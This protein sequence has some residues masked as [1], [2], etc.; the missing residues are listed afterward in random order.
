M[1]VDHCWHVRYKP[2]NI[3][4]IMLYP[5]ACATACNNG[6]RPSSPRQ[7]KNLFNQNEYSMLCNSWDFQIQLTF[8]HS[9]SQIARFA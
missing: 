5:L 6:L 2:S 9:E 1:V 7:N 4:F 3:V 8:F